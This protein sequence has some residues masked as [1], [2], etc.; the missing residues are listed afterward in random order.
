[1]TVVLQSTFFKRITMG[2]SESE[3]ESESP[4]A[5]LKHK[6]SQLTKGAPSLSLSG[7]PIYSSFPGCF[8]R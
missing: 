5:C 2:E 6:H 3:S 1:M 8:P 7:Q 4:E